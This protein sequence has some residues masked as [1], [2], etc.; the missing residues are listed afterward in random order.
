LQQ[1]KDLA[2]AEVLA[3]YQAAALGI[4]CLQH[5]EKQQQ[6]LKKKSADILRYSLK[7][8]NKLEEAEA[9]EKE[10]KEVQERAAVSS[11]VLAEPSW[12]ELL[13]EEQF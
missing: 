7:T 1:E 8:L 11:A 5:L 13:S 12:L 6:F 2:A 3:A 10:E 9:K 4:A